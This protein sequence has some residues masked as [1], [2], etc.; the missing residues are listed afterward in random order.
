M[1]WKPHRLPLTSKQLKYYSNPDNDN[2]GDWNSATYTCNKTR[3]ERPNLYYPIV[4]P[5]TGKEVLPKETA[6]W[7]YSKSQTEVFQE[8]NRLF[9][10]V[11]GTAKMPRIKNF[12]LNMKVLLIEL[13]GI[14][15]M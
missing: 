11:D 13:F 9:W 7:K 15:T 1:L 5:K 8:D 2:R 6:V 12:Y 4:N 14:M 3:E 10:G